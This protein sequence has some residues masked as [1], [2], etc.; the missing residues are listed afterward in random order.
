MPV[1]IMSVSFRLPIEGQN[2][3]ASTLVLCASFT[4]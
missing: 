1:P 3:L 2:A 4:G